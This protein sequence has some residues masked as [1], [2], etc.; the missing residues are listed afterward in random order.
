M[1]TNWRASRVSGGSVTPCKSRIGTNHTNEWIHA[2]RV[3][4]GFSKHPAAAV[5]AAHAADTTSFVLEFFRLLNGRLEFLAALVGFWG[6]W[7]RVGL[8]LL[9]PVVGTIQILLIDDASGGW[10]N[11]LHGL[12]ALVVLLLAVTLAHSG[13]RSLSAA[14]IDARTTTSSGRRRWR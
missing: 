2:I 1:K 4:H 5:S 12:F 3:I 8:A 6:S 14:P 7:K 9:L 10:I 11:G 13:K